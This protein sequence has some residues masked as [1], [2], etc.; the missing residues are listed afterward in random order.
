MGWGQEQQA[1]DHRAKCG[2]EPTP[3]QYGAHRKAPV[4]RVG[5]RAEVARGG[6]SSRGRRSPTCSRPVLP[7]AAGPLPALWRGWNSRRISQAAALGATRM[8][9]AGS[10]AAVLFRPV[11]GASWVLAGTE[12]TMQRAEAARRSRAETAGAAP[13]AGLQPPLPLPGT[14]PNWRWAFTCPTAPPSGPAG[15]HLSTQGSAA[16]PEPRRKG[17]QLRGRRRRRR[18]DAELRP[19]RTP[20][21][22]SRSPGKGL[23]RRLAARQGRSWVQA[24][25]LRFCCKVTRGRWKLRKRLR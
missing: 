10:G 14:E 19:R 22:P 17:L 12:I 8:A 24:E 23:R 5:R 20:A 7:G 4:P 16:R 15:A 13:T 2:T 6:V 1:N 11:P 9:P 3:R 18:Q 25:G 21:Q